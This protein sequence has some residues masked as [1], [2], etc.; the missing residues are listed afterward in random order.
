MFLCFRN[1]KVVLSVK[2]NRQRDFCLNGRTRFVGRGVLIRSAG[3][4]GKINFCGCERFFRL[5][6][7][8]LM[9]QLSVTHFRS[10][11]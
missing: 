5:I 11:V 2:M 4:V 7:S 3:I 6:F 10:T 8:V 9:E 1:L